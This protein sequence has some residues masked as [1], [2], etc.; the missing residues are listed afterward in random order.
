[1]DNNKDVEKPEPLCITDGSGKQWKTFCLVGFLKKLNMELSRDPATSRLGIYPEEL[2]ASARLDICPPVFIAA[3]FAIA[4]RWEQ[5]KHQ[6][7]NG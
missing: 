4:K 6:L 2:R 1:M 3:L 7:M 5:S